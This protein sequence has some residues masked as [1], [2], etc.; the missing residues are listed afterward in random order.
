MSYLIL[1]V[2]VAGIAYTY[3]A[4]LHVNNSK[5]LLAKV[6]RDGHKSSRIR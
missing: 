6:R 3:S 5:V 4:L 2:V 1:P